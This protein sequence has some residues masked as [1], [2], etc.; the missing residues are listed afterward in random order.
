MVAVTFSAARVANP[1]ST[2]A[3]TKGGK[4][5]KSLFSRVFDAIAESQM[6]RAQRELARY[7]HLLPYSFDERGNRLVKTDSHD[8]PFGGW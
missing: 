7:R 5:A 8:M 1:A 3:D 6:K 2:P 4:K